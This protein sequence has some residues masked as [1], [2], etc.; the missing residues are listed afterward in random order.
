MTILLKRQYFA[1]ILF[2]IV[3]ALPSCLTRDIYDKTIPDSSKQTRKRNVE[4]ITYWLSAVNR[5]VRR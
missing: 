1:V 2:P 4:P 5:D 3:R